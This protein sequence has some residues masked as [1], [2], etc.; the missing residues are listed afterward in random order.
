MSTS[1]K[2][3]GTGTG[4]D[5]KSWPRM[6]YSLFLGGRMVGGWQVATT[7]LR[8]TTLIRWSEVGKCDD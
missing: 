8:L 1:S 5:W 2:F 7:K 3:R 6:S 4:R